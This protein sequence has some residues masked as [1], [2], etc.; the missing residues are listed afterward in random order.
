MGQRRQSGGPG[1]LANGCALLLSLGWCSDPIPHPGVPGELED[2]QGLGQGRG[3]D[4]G[5]REKRRDGRGRKKD[6]KGR[7]GLPWWRSG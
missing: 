5:R 2:Q 7:E 1:V 4:K 6:K 3:T